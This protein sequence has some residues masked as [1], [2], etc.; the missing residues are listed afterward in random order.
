MTPDQPPDPASN[1]TEEEIFRETRGMY[2]PNYAFDSSITARRG[3]SRFAG[4]IAASALLASL[5]LF[6]VGC[7]TKS[8]PITKPPAPQVTVAKVECK[9]VIETDEFTGRLEAA[10][11]LIG[12]DHRLALHLRH[13]N[14][15]RR[16][17]ASR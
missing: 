14:L 1:T 10:R 4:L 12:L 6:A 11:K 15:R 5:A 17:S 13:R 8:A 2:R 9:P 3:A 16:R 7:D